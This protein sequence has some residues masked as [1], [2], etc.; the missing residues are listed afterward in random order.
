MY[1]VCSGM[2]DP[3]LAEI[4]A[5]DSNETIKWLAKN[6]V[7][8]QFSLNRQTYEVD[9]RFKFWG[10]LSLET[11]DGGSV[12]MRITKLLPDVMA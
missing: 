3:S 7:R 1:R 8:F 11:Q 2:S 12:L 10:G 6:V 5:M 9:G 4:L